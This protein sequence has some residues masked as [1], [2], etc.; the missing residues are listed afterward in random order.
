MSYNYDDLY[1][2]PTILILFVCVLYISLDYAPPPHTHTHTGAPGH[3]LQPAHPH[4]PTLQGDQEDM[5]I[6]GNEVLERELGIETAP[7]RS[8]RR[9]APVHMLVS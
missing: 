3:S 4:G 1:L 2:S 7:Y 5:A 9:E 6:L 8:R